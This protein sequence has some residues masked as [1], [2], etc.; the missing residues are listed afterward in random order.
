MTTDQECHPSGRLV[1]SDKG[2][3]RRVMCPCGRADMDYTAPRCKKCA[4]DSRRDYWRDYRRGLVEARH[5]T[6]SLC[7]TPVRNYRCRFCEECK[8]DRVR[9]RNSMEA[10]R[11]G[12]M[13]L[14]VDDFT[15]EQIEARYQRAVQQKRH[16]AALAR[17]GFGLSV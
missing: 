3:R 10:R 12:T 8:R 13:P 16:D 4:S 9:F 15:P 7:P 2:Q 6:C 5:L 1:R 11:A 17:L 14:P